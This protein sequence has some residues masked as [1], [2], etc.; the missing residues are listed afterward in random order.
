MVRDWCQY[1]GEGVSQDEDEGAEDLFSL[2]L[3]FNLDHCVDLIAS[4]N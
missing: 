1:R 2:L 4:R 3:F